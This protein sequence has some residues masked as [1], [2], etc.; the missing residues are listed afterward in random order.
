MR[1]ALAFAFFTLVRVSLAF[2]AVGDKRVAEPAG[3]PFAATA[4]RNAKR[5]SG[6]VPSVTFDPIKQKVDVTGKHTFVPPKTGDQRVCL[7]YV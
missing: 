2:P 3:C 5:Q 6:T 4:A 7:I 1:S